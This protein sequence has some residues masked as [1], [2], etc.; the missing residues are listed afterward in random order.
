MR[1]FRCNV[2]CHPSVLLASFVWS[3]SSHWAVYCPLF[4][5]SIFPSWNSH[6]IIPLS[7]FACRWEVE[8]VVPPTVPEQWSSHPFRQIW[9]VEFCL[10]FLR[11]PFAFGGFP[12][13]SHWNALSHGQ[14]SWSD[15]QRILKPFNLALSSVYIFTIVVPLIFSLFVLKHWLLVMF[16]VDG[17]KY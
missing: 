16:P 14:C 5:F 2:N 12:F 6:N 13:L 4:F 10:W 9:V 7:N 1:S 15:V 3:S 11:Y 17:A 8:S